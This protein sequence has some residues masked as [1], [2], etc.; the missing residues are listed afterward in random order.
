M[1]LLQNVEHLLGD[2]DNTAEGELLQV[3]NII[4]EISA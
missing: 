4:R 2:G 3:P 1:Q